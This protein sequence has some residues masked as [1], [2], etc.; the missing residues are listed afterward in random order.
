MAIAGIGTIVTIRAALAD[1][2]GANKI[3]GDDATGKTG[4]VTDDDPPLKAAINKWLKLGEV[5][6]ITGPSFSKEQI[7]VTSM[8]TTGGYREFISGLKDAGEISFAM[9]FTKPVYNAM[10]GVFNKVGESGKY[11]WSMVLND[12]TAYASRSCF[13]FKGSVTGAPVQ[14]PIEDKITMNLTIRASGLVKF[15]TVGAAVGPTTR[16]TGLAPNYDL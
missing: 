13:W 15:G 4:L 3:F 8:D 7:D 10:I 2:V 14:I 16:G 5:N 9:N 12:A 6:S 1:D 11:D